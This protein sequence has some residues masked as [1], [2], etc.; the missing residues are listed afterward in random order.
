MSEE[1]VPEELISYAIQLRKD[2]PV[3][4]L[5]LPQNLTHEDVHRLQQF[6]STLALEG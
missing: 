1:Q 5:F 2:E 4:R 3:S 6:L